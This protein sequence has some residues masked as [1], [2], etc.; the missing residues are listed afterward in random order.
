MHKLVDEEFE[1]KISAII[2]HLFKDP[3]ISAELR[4]FKENLSQKPSIDEL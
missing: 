4:E 1:D 2:E 3:K